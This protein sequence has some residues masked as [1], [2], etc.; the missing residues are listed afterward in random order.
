LIDFVFIYFLFSSDYVISVLRDTRS[1]ATR[2]CR[3]IAGALRKHCAHLWEPP[4][5]RDGLASAI[6]NGY[7]Y[8]YYI[9]YRQGR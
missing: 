4:G 2:E 8:R 7:W 3:S 1:I 6:Y 9:V 5:V